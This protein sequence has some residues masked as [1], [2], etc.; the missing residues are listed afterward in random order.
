M[1]LDKL[2][3]GDEEQQLHSK[4]VFFQ[5]TAKRLKEVWFRTFRLLQERELAIL[6]LSEAFQG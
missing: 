5:E 3:K 2:V 4:T 6:L 1:L